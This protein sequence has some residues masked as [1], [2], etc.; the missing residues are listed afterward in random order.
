MKR[1]RIPQ[2]CPADIR[3]NYLRALM[4]D[5]WKE[6]QAG[7][8]RFGGRRSHYMPCSL[9][10]AWADTKARPSAMTTAALMADFTP[11]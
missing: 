9:T 11:R 5:A 6:A 2:P 8:D 10:L 3:R 7:A 1:P 4:M